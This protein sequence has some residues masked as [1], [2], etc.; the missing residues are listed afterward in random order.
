[1]KT[2]YGMYT[3]EIFDADWLTVRSTYIILMKLLFSFLYTLISMVHII[4]TIL[5]IENTIMRE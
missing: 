3:I 4:I 1:M 2:V 5:Y